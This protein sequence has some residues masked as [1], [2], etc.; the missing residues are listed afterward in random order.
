MFR[1]FF[2]PE[3]GRF[4]LQVI[5]LHMFWV[6]V[7]VDSFSTGGIESTPI[8]VKQ[9]THL[10][11]PTYEAATNYVKS[12][13]LDLLYED[14][15]ANKFRQYMSDEKETPNIEQAFNNLLK[16]MKNET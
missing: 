14:R 16:A 11:F 3:T 12:I 2:D 7:K 5:K 15:S 8:P 9:K 13:G 4:K 1:I 6:N 10:S